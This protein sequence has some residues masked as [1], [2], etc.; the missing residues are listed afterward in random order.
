MVSLVISKN[1]EDPFKNESARVVT[2]FLPLK[3][4][5]DFSRCS[6]AANSPVRGWIWP[7]FKLVQAFIAV[8]ITYKNE[9][10]PIKLKIKALEWSQH[11][12]H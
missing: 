9:E 7:K 10:D 2:T 12:S 4:Y 3:V 8:L 11:F 1:E 6:R 5:G